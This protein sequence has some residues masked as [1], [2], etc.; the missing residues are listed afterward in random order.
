VADIKTLLALGVAPSRISFT[1]AWKPES[2]IRFAR[3]KQVGLLSFDNVAELQKIARN[4]PGAR[5]LLRVGGSVLS[6]NRS[7]PNLKRLE[8]AEPRVPEGIASEPVQDAPS[9]SAADEGKK[10]ESEAAS[11]E[12]Q[13]QKA[14]KRVTLRIDPDA[15]LSEDT[16]RA[17]LSM[18][19]QRRH[20][21]ATLNQVPEL[22]REAK[23]LNVTLVGVNVSYGRA[24]QD[25]QH[26]RR[27]MKD[28]RYVFQ[29]AR[30]LGF[31]L[32]VVDIGGIVPPDT[33]PATSG[34]AVHGDGMAQDSN[35][36][37]PLQEA[38]AQP[39][40]A[41]A[42]R[43]RH[44]HER[45]QLPAYVSSELDSLGPAVQV[46][47]RNSR[48]VV[49]HS[50]TLAVS[51][52]ARRLIHHSAKSDIESALANEEQRGDESKDVDEV[53]PRSVA[54]TPQLLSPSAGSRGAP[55]PSPTASEKEEQPREG[56]AFIYYLNDGLY[57][58]FN[59]VL[60]EKRKLKPHLVSGNHDTSRRYPAIVYGPTCDGVDCIYEHID[61]PELKVGDWLYFRNMGAFAAASAT[62]FNGFPPPIV[63][64]VLS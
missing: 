13:S 15:P 12:Q 18:L 41:E 51:V 34:S 11:K 38:Q 23:R 63:R 56:S 43:R 21:G 53:D 20:Q 29:K 47:G 49:S 58:S 25:A 42:D 31:D 60:Y 17:R 62:S 10:S 61:L 55:A 2:Q 1:N 48:Y 64:Y 22:L 19:Q 27:L 24:C 28:V 9:A 7:A 32:S 40:L 44:R 57:G 5:L 33:R 6:R 37:A 39:P 30:Q 14:T 4:Y 45:L 36:S 3:D 50:H 35:A 8:P 26:F 46:I 59:C 52:I 54:A 16:K